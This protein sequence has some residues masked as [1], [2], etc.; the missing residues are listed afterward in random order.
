MKQKRKNQIGVGGI[1]LEDEEKYYLNKV[2]ESNRL[3]YG[4]VTQKFE[5]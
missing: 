2:I 5:T 1:V 3:S 4:P